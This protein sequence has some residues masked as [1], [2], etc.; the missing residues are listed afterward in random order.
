MQAEGATRRD[1]HEILKMPDGDW[2]R[3]AWYVDGPFTCTVFLADGN[4]FVDLRNPAFGL[5]RGGT[6]DIRRVADLLAE[7][8]RACYGTKQVKI[9]RD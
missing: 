8:L 7:N 3:I 2:V 9:K 5:A 6:G 4:M 1:V